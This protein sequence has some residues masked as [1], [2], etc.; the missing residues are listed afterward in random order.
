MNATLLAAKG[1]VAAI[2]AQ[3]GPLSAAPVGR[4]ASGEHAVPLHRPAHQGE[5]AGGPPALDH[6]PTLDE[7]A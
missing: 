4:V 5:H 1:E 6:G 2:L 3:V 7:R